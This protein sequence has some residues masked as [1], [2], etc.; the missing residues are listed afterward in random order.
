MLPYVAKKR[1]CRC[2]YTEALDWKDYLNYLDEPN[3]VTKVLIREG[4]KCQRPRVDV[5][6]EREVGVTGCEIG[7]KRQKP[8][9]ARAF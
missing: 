5:M 3:V 8:R 9:N 6:K 4:Q 1:L 7:G 2:D